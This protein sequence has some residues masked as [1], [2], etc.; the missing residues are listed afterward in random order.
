MNAPASGAGVPDGDGFDVR[1]L[2]L[3][4]KVGAQLGS[5]RHPWG[6]LVFASSGVMSVATDT[7]AWL[8]PPTKAIWLPAGVAHRITARGELA[9][10]TLY[11][12]AERAAG[13]AARPVALEVA[14]LLRELILH[15]LAIGM[16]NPAR[17]EHDRLAGLLVDLL[18]A[19]RQQDLSLPLPAERRARELAT[20]ILDAPAD[21]IGLAELADQVGASLRT[22]Q[23][24]FPRE[25][26]LT[27]EAWRQ[28]ARLVH[29]VG[30][31]C[32]GAR[33]TDA[34]YDCGYRSVGAFIAA[35]AR[36]F[37]VTPGRYFSGP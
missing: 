16:L 14:P 15:I 7:E 27:P 17:P 5:H 36:Q 25:T 2:A 30:S 11:L 18:R 4:L 31:L 8:V 32:T 28:K 1:T 23:R 12:G 35:F 29:A 21:A 26:G 34:A 10:R 20:R 24:V 6:Q 22:M 13:L 33:V 3:G 19:A 9:M 37:G